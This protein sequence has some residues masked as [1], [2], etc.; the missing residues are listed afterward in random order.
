MKKT[1]VVNGAAHSGFGETTARLIISEGNK[2]IGL[3]SAEDEEN[4]RKLSNEKC[5]V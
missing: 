1:Y 4:A 5:S 2:V 3:Y